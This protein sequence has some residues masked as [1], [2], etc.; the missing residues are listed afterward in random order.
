[1]FSQG[2]FFRD[3]GL[4]A[5]LS[6]DAFEAQMRAY[7]QRSVEVFS[8][9]ERGFG[10]R[11]RLVRVMA[12]QAANPWASETVLSFRD[13]HRATDALAIAPYFGGYL[14]EQGDRVQSMSLAALAAELETKAVDEALEW[15]EQQARVA[16]QY[17]VPLITYEGGQHLVGIGPAADNARL[18][19]L[20][21]AVNRDGRMRR[22]YQRYLAGWRRLGGT[23]FVHYAHCAQNS[24][25]GRWGAIEDL[26][27]PRKMAPKFDALLHFAEHN[28]RWWGT[29]QAGSP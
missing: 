5:G 23:L 14:G 2:E 24:K 9:F 12:S 27:Q 10:G 19:E 26:M 28:P 6:D 16:R 22:I 13:A 11:S 3:R 21:S 29:T 20:F 8:L 25:F 15:V 17:R 1:M 18:N 7:S 4:R